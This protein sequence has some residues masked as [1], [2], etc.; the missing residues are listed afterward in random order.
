MKKI[1]CIFNII[2]IFLLIISC[3]SSNKV[4]KEYKEV[5][6]TNSYKSTNRIQIARVHF[7]FNKF[8]LTR[9]FIE[10]AIL[11][12]LRTNTN[13][14]KLYIYGH[15]DN[16]GKDWWNYRLGLHRALT[17]SNIISTNYTSENI[18]LKSFSYSNSIADNRTENGRYSNRRA[19]IFI[20]LVEETFEIQTNLI[21]VD[22]K[23][24]FNILSRFNIDL[25]IL[26]ILLLIILIVI[27][28]ILI[29]FICNSFT[30]MIN[31]IQ[32]IPMPQF[33]KDIIYNK[34]IK[35]LKNY[36]ENALKSTNKTLR[37]NI[38]EQFT[39]LDKILKRGWKL[40]F[41]K[42][43]PK[44][45]EDKGHDGIDAIFYKN[46]KFIIVESK[47]GSS[48]LN[49]ETDDGKQMSVKWI[50]HRLKKYCEGND[51]VY[52]K[53]IKAINEGNVKYMVAKIDKNLDTIDYKLLDRNAN[54]TGELCK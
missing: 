18:I 54:Y 10:N 7:D 13:I 26:L 32:S 27:I 30:Y 42:N 17:V 48:E 8:N 11:L 22:S 16:K 6:S 23:N 39:S 12:D 53:I 51:N 2:I 21:K 44:N 5:I 50:K 33:L 34:W 14:L 46:G 45:V 47:Y 4:N 25:R 37:G 20:D 36:L 29:I 9:D 19:D 43:I 52:N 31:I 3:S 28:I 15:T 49:P 40:L 38:G 24:E 41:I 35:K 1:K